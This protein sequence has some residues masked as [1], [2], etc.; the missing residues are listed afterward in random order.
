[1]AGPFKEPP[2]QDFVVLP[3]GVVPK[4]EPNKFRLIHHLSYP[5]GASVNDG[6][7]PELCSVVYTSFD[8]ALQWIRKVYTEH[9]LQISLQYLTMYKTMELMTFA[10]LLCLAGQALT[11]PVQ[12]HPVKNK[13]SAEGPTVFE[14]ILAANKGIRK[15]LNGGDIAINIYR[16]AIKCEE[17]KWP[18]N[19]NGSAQVPYVL[20]PQYSFEKAWS[21]NKTSQKRI[22]FLCKNFISPGQSY[23][24]AF[25]TSWERELAASDK[26]LINSALKE[27]GVMTCVQFVNQSTESDY[28]SIESGSGCWSY[29]GRI[30]GK[31][32]VSLNSPGCMVYGI[33]HHE[34]MHNIGFYHEHTRVDRNQYVYVE[35]NN[36]E[37]D[38]WGNF[39]IVDGNTLNRP[40]DYKSVMHYG[41]NDF[42]IGEG[43]PTLVPVPDSTVFIG[44]RSGMSTLDVDKINAYYSCNLC[45][46]KLVTASGS[47]SG[48]SSSANKSSDGMCLWLIQV[49][50]SRISLQ[51]DNLAI[52]STDYVKVFDGYTESS[53][54]LLNETYGNGPI[55]PLVSS[56][57][58]MLVEFVSAASS[59]SSTFQASYSTV[60]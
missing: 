27:F 35:W 56:G 53:P 50:D 14:L 29:I 33:I 30:G 3:L 60:A 15:Y 1:M 8:A 7:D 18:K 38:A 22:S 28:L 10:L 55:T 6:I 2:V 46:R 16:N 12:K 37:K 32:T 45:R 42:S 51:F 59:N 31:Q 36:I 41:R 49:P 4:K 25:L 34:G 26:D 58:N 47:L 11:K 44:Q 13:N 5:K 39:D 43:L 52:S 20:D 17:C 23:K 48:D 21:E 40:Y 57:R 9:L 24:P 19:E 54:V